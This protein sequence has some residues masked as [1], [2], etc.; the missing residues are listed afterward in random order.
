M[1]SASLVLTVLQS[2]VKKGISSRGN[3]IIKGASCETKSLGEMEIICNSWNRVCVGER[4]RRKYE[5]YI[6]NHTTHTV[7][8]SL[9]ILNY[10]EI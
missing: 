4:S 8:P 6:Q 1:I 9:K 10:Q 7:K 3:G 5:I 2:I